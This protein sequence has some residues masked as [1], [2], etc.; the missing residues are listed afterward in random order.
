[1]IPRPVSALVTA[2]GSG[3]AGL[4]RDSARSDPRWEE[5]VRLDLRYPESLSL[6]FDPVVPARTGSAVAPGSGPR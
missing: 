1:V 6:P 5:A 2:Y 3:M 4:W